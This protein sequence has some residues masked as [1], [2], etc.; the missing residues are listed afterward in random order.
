MPRRRSPFLA[1]LAALLWM[2]VAHAVSVGNGK[3]VYAT[4]CAQCHNAKPRQ[5]SGSVMFGANYAPGIQLAIDGRVPDMSILQGV[6]SASDV[7]DV[8]AYLGSL[9]GSGGTGTLNVPSALNFASQEV[10]TQSSATQLT[11]ANTGSASVSIFSVSSNNLAEFPVTGNNCTGTVIAGGNCKI[12]VAFMP[13]ASGARGGTITVASSGTGSPQSIVASGSGTA[14]PP[15]PPPPPPPPAPTAAVI[16]YYW[17]ARD[18]YFITSAAAEIAA[19]D[20]AAPGGWFRTGRTFKT[21]PAP[22]TGSSSVCRFYLPAQ[23]GDSHFYGRSAAECDATHAANPGF[24]Y[25]SPA[26]MYMD[27]PTLGVCAT[28]TVPVYRVFSARV[29]TNHRYTTD[30]AIRDLM[31]AQGWLAEGDGPDLVVMCAPP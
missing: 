29:D 31:V 8:A 15:P 6:L 20:A 5:D 14:A 28:G 10:G 27:L 24:F 30:R 2:P 4:W 3:S 18:H 12:K 9:Q 23:Y 17:A 25:E 13:S 16:E 1:L 21:L 26:V 7:D 11:I 22:Q 19:L